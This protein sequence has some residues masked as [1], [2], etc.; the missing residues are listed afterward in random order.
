MGYDFSLDVESRNSLSVLLKRVKPDSVV[1]EFGPAHGRMTK[2]LKEELGCRVYGVEIDSEAVKDAEKYAEKIVVDDIE[3]FHWVKEFEGIFFDYIIFADVLEHLSKPENVLLQVKEFLKEDGSVLVS[4]PNIAHNAIII[5]LLKERFDYSDNGILD[6][7][8]VKF[9]TKKTFDALIKR[10]GYF[11]GYESAIYLS[12][13]DSEFK[14]SYDELPPQVKEYLLSLP[15]GEFYQLIYE[16]KKCGNVVKESDFSDEYKSF[17]TSYVQIFV[18]DEGE[19]SEEKSIRVAFTNQN[20]VTFDLSGYKNIK[21]LRFD[22]LDSYLVLKVGS[23]NIDK[24]SLYKKE[25]KSNAMYVKDDVYFFDTQDPQLFLELDE[26]NNSPSYISFE[27]EYLYI[28]HEAQSRI[29]LLQKQLF[30]DGQKLLR[31]K[32]LYIKNLQKEVGEKELQ[33][34]NL[35]DTVIHLHQIAQSMRIKNRVKRV[36]PKSIKEFL[37]WG[38]R[39]YAVLKDKY[40]KFRVLAEA[41]GTIFTCKQALRS[42]LH[43]TQALSFKKSE[44]DIKRFETVDETISIVIPTYNGL[45][46]LTKLIPQLINQKG[47]RHIE[48]IVVDS[49]SSDGS[50]EFL[51]KFSNVQIFSI[52]QKEFSH[53]Y[54]RNLGFE[55]CSGKYVLFLVQDALP[56]SDMWLYRFYNILQDN[57]LSALSC[58]Q[59]VNSEADLYACYSIDNFNKFLG[60]KEKATKITEKYIENSNISRNLAQ[61]D[62]VAC[63]FRSN[64]FARYK[65]RGKYAEDLDIGL[66]LIKDGHKIGITSQTCVIH[67]HLRP[68]YYYMKR[69]MVE[70]DAL[71]DIFECVIEKNI[72]IKKE[73]SDIFGSFFL[74]GELLS[75]LD[76]CQ[77]F[78]LN[79]GYFNNLVRGYLEECISKE[80]NEEDFLSAYD[81]IKKYDLDMANMFNELYLHKVTLFRGDLFYTIK[82][83]VIQGLDYMEQ[84]YERID[85]NIFSE[86]RFFILKTFATNVGEKIGKHKKEFENYKS[87]VSHLIE[88]LS[89]GV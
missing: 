66:R 18:E 79:F 67:S 17:G 68:A 49:M 54:A 77:R 73:L 45:N 81:K 26:S 56:E 3:S 63:M 62:N 71:N 52:S 33:I 20:R 80:Y 59:I 27:L 23:I 11:I 46:D 70:S 10:C 32:D 15:H 31:E 84:K 69:A 8:H 5:N 48:I 58:I 29:S 16:I 72:D 4:V 76:E 6:K 51:K 2:Y 74:I 60:L 83:L 75:R 43:K 14:N 82:H 21:S 25:I 28:K 39:K 64:I 30:F 85:D 50:V 1:L 36:L 42:K 12:P 47:F 86:Y 78:P 65:F 35:Q 19:Y 9:F 40:D 89:K 57:A 55:K 24:E 87:F 22:P 41:N 34:Q 7:T 37:K 53:S 61:L 88:K 13:E 44:L 38:F